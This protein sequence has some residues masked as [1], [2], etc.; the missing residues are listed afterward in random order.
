[1]IFLTGIR[2]AV[3]AIPGTLLLSALLT[4]C[5]SAVKATYDPSFQPQPGT[6][7]RL[8]DVVESASAEA[9][10][11]GDLDIPG[12][13]RQQIERSLEDAGLLA[14]AGSIGP[15]VELSVRIE[16][17]APGSALGGRYLRLLDA[18]SLVLEGEIRDRGRDVGTL[19][20]D[21]EVKGGLRTVEQRN[22]VFGDAASDLVRQ[23]ADKLR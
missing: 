22:D 4:G 20:V 23:L 5:G 14:S 7:V 2:R 12:E 13:M 21:R 8:G 17:Y 16:R 18:T 15:T 9:G 6:M 1:M 11:G 3:I 10:G 19:T